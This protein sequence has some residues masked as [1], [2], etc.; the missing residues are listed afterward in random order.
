[1]TMKEIW[2]ERELST[3][4]IVS[5]L[6]RALGLEPDEVMVTTRLTDRWMAWGGGVLVHPTQEDGELRSRLMIVLR[7]GAITRDEIL[8]A[9]SKAWEC[10]VALRDGGLDARAMMLSDRGA[11]PTRIRYEQGRVVKSESRTFVLESAGGDFRVLV[12]PGETKI[13][14]RSES[15]DT[16]L[17]HPAVDLRQAIV[18]H[19]GAWCTIQDAGSEAGTWVNELRADEPIALRPGD[20]VQLGS[21]VLLTRV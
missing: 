1:M 6:A 15:V 20:S 4:D 19:D 16:R 8:R 12:K 9:L 2:A 5:G 11:K 14:G 18:R 10:Q 7:R 3:S 13:V 21:L 17:D